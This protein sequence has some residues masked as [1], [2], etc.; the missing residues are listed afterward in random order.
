[1]TPRSLLLSCLALLPFCAL[2]D[3]LGVNFGSGRNNA[4]LGTNDS[5]GVIPQTNWNNASGDTGT[6]SN[7]KD[8]SGATKTTNIT[9]NI[10]EQ[11]SDGDTP[12]DANGTLMK[13]WISANDNASPGSIQI[14]S[15]P[16]TTYDLY[17]YLNHDRASEDVLITETRSA[18]PDFLAQENDPSITGPITFT[19]QLESAATNPAASG[20]Y[21]RF[22][23]LTNATLNLK[24]SPDGS[25]GSADRGAIT[26]LQIVETV[27]LAG[28][29]EV[30][31]SSASALTPNS[32]S[33]GGNLIDNGS[34]ADTATLSFS[35]GLTDGGSTPAAW[36]AS[37]S[38]GSRTSPGIFSASLASLQPGTTYFYRSFA[39]NSIGDDDASES[40][41][42][43]TPPAPAS[44]TNQPASDIS[45]TSASLSAEVTATGG[46][47]PNLIIYYGDND[48]GTTTA[49]WD[50]QLN[51]GPQSGTASSPIS[52]L[53]PNTTHHFRASATNETGT[54]WASASST[55]QTLPLLLPT[56]AI[57][58]ATSVND[59]FASLSGQITDTG[60]EP[61]NVTLFYGT[62]DGGQNPGN[63]QFTTAI[64]SQDSRFSAFITKLTPTT[65]YHFTARAQNAAGDAWANSSL[66]FTTP[67]FVAPSVVINE[68]HY[69]ESDKTERAEFIEL[70]NPGNSA[71]DL[72]GYRFTSGIDFTFPS[73]SIIPPGGYFVVAEDPSFAA[74]KFSLTDPLGP[75]ANGTGLR[76]SGETITLSDPGGTVIDEVSY[77]LGFP[78]P[79]VGDELGSPPS[80]PSI[81][82]LNPSLDN[83]LGGSWRASGFPAIQG[84]SG[85]GNN[86]PATLL[87]SAQ[88]GWRYRNGL[89]L[90]DDDSSNK[91]WR[92]N[93]YLDSDDGEWLN[94]TTPIGFGDNDDTTVLTDMRNSYVSVYLRKEF[95]IAPGE[96]PSEI[97]LDC[98]HDDGA[99]IYL[100]GIEIGR[101]SVE[102]GPV[103]FPAPNGFANNHEADWTEITL[104]ETSA[105]LVEGTNVIA[106]QAINTTIT[107]SDFSIDARITAGSTASYQPT[108]GAPNSSFA[109]ATPP[110]I[111][112]IDHAPAQPTSGQEVTVTAKVTDPDALA[113]V[114]LQY[115]LVE[116]GDYFCRYLKFSSN[117]NPNLD[118]RYED[119]AEWTSLTMTDDGTSGDEFANDDVFS[120]TLPS[121][122]QQNR[123]L[124]RYRISASDATDNAITVPYSDDPQPNF[125]YF[126]YDGT[127]AWSGSIRPGDAPVTYP[128]SLMSS[129]PTY[130][131]LT[132][133]AWTNDSQFGRYSGSE[134]LWPG[135]MVYDGRVYDHIQYRPRG[136]VHRYQYGKN[137]WKFDFNRGHRFQARD[138]YGK[139]YDTEWSKL[140]FSSIVQ[141]VNFNHR[142][143]QGLF[144]S[145]G[146]KLFKLAGVEACHT[147][148]TQFYVVDDAHAEGST[149]YNSDYYG[150]YLAIE[151]M[152]GQYLEE[153][154]LPDGNLYKIE[155]HNG[156]SN[157]QGA[158]QVSDRSDVS[159][160][161]SAYRNGTP[162]A[163]WWRENLDLEKYLSYR[164]IVEGIHHYDIAGGKNYFY[165]NNPDTNKF[166]VHPW[167]L[168]LTWANNMYGSGNHNFKTKVA[169]NPAFN[170]DYQ[171]RVRELMDL[172]YNND[173]GARVIDEVVKDVWTPGQPSLVGADRRLWD[174]NP[175][176]T[177]PDRYYDVAAN[178]EFDGMI[179]ILKN[180][181]VS[182]GSWMTSNLLTDRA[183]IPATPV[184][185]QT[186][187]TL[188]FTSTNY[189]SPSNTTFANMEWRISEISNPDTP[190]Y[191][192]TEPYK[193]EIEAPFESGPLPAFSSNYTFPLI[194]ARPGQTY[195]ARVRHQD[196]AG[197]WSHWSAPAEF[198]AATPDV[199]LYQN[200]L[201][202]S[203]IMF[204]PAAPSGAEL[205]LSSENDDFEFIEIQNVG[206]QT[207]DLT[208]I[209]FTK[210]IDFDFPD[211]TQIAPGAHLLIVKNIAAFESRY[212]P[213]LPIAGSYGGDNLSNGG[214]QIKLSL[215]AGTAILDFTYRD[216]S[217][218]PTGTDGDG[219]SLSL[220]LPASLP[221]HTLPT[222]WRISTAPNGTPNQDDTQT[223]GSW[224]IANNVTGLPNDDDDGDG[225]SNLM[226]FALLGAPLIPDPSILPTV[227]ILD[228]FLTLTFDRPIAADGLTYIVEFSKDLQSWRDESSLLL[229]S[230]PSAAGSLTQIWRNQSNLQAS[231]GAFARLR[232][233]IN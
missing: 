55:F 164:S 45:A 27:T 118:P 228:E 199:S 136:G 203:E 176:I 158:N 79:T 103:T 119:P 156:D 152:D 149:Q 123:R 33:L 77:S 150:L 50:S 202:I 111:R 116:P 226:E 114:T 126:V 101:F 165:F 172:L 104:T 177:S 212:G 39:T 71:S 64:G 30:A 102:A 105:Y 85:P 222:S 36:N 88:S 52:N 75:F 84:N 179:N 15:I 57:S 44:V 206:A 145:T 229:S 6:L 163:Q 32:A 198:S 191:D 90:P 232:V 99:I 125:A 43:T 170:T 11:W 134:Y 110:Q 18:F 69:D 214:E 1:M 112:Q 167:D 175:N 87:A 109:L 107:S 147:H 224:A 169:Q 5:A 121:S 162:T 8:D 154:G 28:L 187:N 95:T 148:Y 54:A 174:N 34:G 196:A 231:P 16:F 137:F 4:S 12:A 68:I 26:G 141:Q 166:E 70:H 220:L 61:P 35:W 171:N 81:E 173:E 97:T 3:S 56:I 131:L 2:A 192:P 74:S 185:S 62:T 72:S 127:P 139:K 83:D 146:F 58:P 124:V 13:G 209:R 59:T 42:F 181:T 225:I 117:G 217:P 86:N 155:G 93:G 132:T 160:F 108:P 151:Q 82:L 210:G 157:N 193:F 200:S 221:D 46:D 14:S 133:S 197:R 9:W 161:I 23:G 211:G 100:N 31:N 48:G 135:S 17:I 10:D 140:N 233:T 91:T 21:V 60:G 219:F 51:L 138:S 183:N 184:I 22:E 94:A 106:I 40:T 130:T 115:Q 66:T 153:H 194:S 159:T 122:L 76:N 143:E 186:G 96:I 37:I 65:T 182:R 29:P 144:E 205:A 142:G 216:S 38:G 129:V 227:S 73:G 213:D 215:G 223:Y 67:V 178:K 188:A 128:G 201:V 7:L 53:S 80:S 113:S 63:W 20:T 92:D 24:L 218:W 230:T 47:T 204:N 195:R 98:Y 25:T 89:T 78:W 49:N 41:T 208:G 168:D 190:T 120:V 19:R 180:Y 207:L 189:S